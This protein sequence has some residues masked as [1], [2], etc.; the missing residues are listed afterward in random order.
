MIGTRYIPTNS[1]DWSWFGYEP[2][3]R[4][5]NVRFVWGQWWH[6]T[7]INGVIQRAVSVIK[8]RVIAAFVPRR[9]IEWTRRIFLIKMPC[10]SARRWKSKT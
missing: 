4:N 6:E 5:K 3:D 10:W 2:P 8:E 7:E 9:A 1:S